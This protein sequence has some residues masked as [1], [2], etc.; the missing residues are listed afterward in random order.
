MIAM[1]WIRSEASKWKMF[2]SNRVSEILTLTCPSRWR[3]CPGKQN[4]ADKGTRGISAKALVEISDW[5]SGPK[6]LVDNTVSAENESC[7]V[8]TNLMCSNELLSQTES[9][10]QKNDEFTFP[11]ARWGSFTKAIR[12]LA[13]ILRFMSNLKLKRKDRNRSNELKLSE[14]TEGKLVLLRH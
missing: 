11:L 12:V 4:P 7:P 13:W 8:E 5:T 14:V 2:V 1:H 10:H 3:H 6:W 9:H